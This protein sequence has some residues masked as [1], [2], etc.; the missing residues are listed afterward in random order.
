VFRNKNVDNFATN[1]PGR[2]N[3]IS[4][5]VFKA[6]ILNLQFRQ[7]WPRLLSKTFRIK[8]K[9]YKVKFT[10]EQATKAQRGRKGIVLLFL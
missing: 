4:V 6:P 10:I 5:Y 7:L 8:V 9:R 1:N 2:L 3:L